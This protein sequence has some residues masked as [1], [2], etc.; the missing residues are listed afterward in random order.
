MTRESHSALPKAQC[1]Y[2]Y[3]L[4]IS[5]FVCAIS[6]DVADVQ[7]DK[8]RPNISLT[9]LC[10]I[11]RP[12]SSSATENVH[13]LRQHPTVCEASVLVTV[14]FCNKKFQFRILQQNAHHARQDAIVL[15]FKS[16]FP[17]QVFLEGKVCDAQIRRSVSTH[18]HQH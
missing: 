4:Q 18:L 17:T 6:V 11:I 2:M 7:V 12:S 10:S 16:R 8:P 13:Q 5:K 9:G 15:D 3:Q 14:P 1:E